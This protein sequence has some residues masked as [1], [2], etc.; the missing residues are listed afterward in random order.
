MLLPQ[1][2]YD[3]IAYPGFPYPD[4]HPD[5]LAAM[6]ILH[7]LTPA[8]VEKCRVLEIACNEGGNLI[9]MAYAIP[10]SEFVGFDLARLP[11]ERGQQRIR[12]LGIRNVRIFQSDLLEVGTELGPFDYIIA[13]GLYSWVPAQV[14][15]RLLALCGAL[16]TANGVAFVSYNTMPG[17]HLRK[18]IREMMLYHVKEIENPNEWVPQSLAFLRYLL[19]TRPEGD[20]YRLLIQ[21]HL[22]K[23]EKRPPETVFHDELSHAYRP[24]HFSEFVEHA[25]N[26]GLQYLSEAVL[27]PPPDPAY[28]SDI[29]SALEEAVGDDIVKQEQMLDFMRARSYRETL[30]CRAECAVRRDFPAEQFQRLMFAS[31]AES[32][33][34]ETVGSKIFS[35]PGGIKM[36]A[37]HPGAIALLEELEA[38]WP[39]SL[40]LEEMQPRLAS[41][42][43]LLDGEGATLLMRLVVS[44]FVELHAWN[45]PVA[46]A[47]SALPRA[48]AC[49]R[50]E[51]QAHAFATTL[52][53][54]SLGI[55]DPV[56]RCF[57]KLL[58]GTRDRTALLDAIRAEFPSMPV[59]ELE[60]GIEPGLKLFQRSGLLEA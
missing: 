50:Q 56:V 2:S 51:A 5:R 30:L 60:A 45:A 15:E 47:V 35:L 52:L 14:S 1:E 4:T 11:I 22:G 54:G 17:G 55:D 24:V 40:R 53:H 32:A 10:G 9:P 12:E 8:P 23:M 44:K 42:G 34:G 29:R 46:T 43:F 26:C 58:D 49:G 27:P 48:S 19:Q 37:N 16:L 38:G 13:H 59:T 31:Q 28:R 3:S 33:P 25:R 7:G 36:E 6:A 20:A 39:R 18:M 41:A 21:E 57:L